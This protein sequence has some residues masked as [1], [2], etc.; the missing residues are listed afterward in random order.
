MRI[1]PLLA[2]TALALAVPVLGNDSEAAV[3]LGGIELVEN[4]DISMDSE[5]LFISKEQVRVRYRYTNHS[6]RDQT[7]VIAFPLPP[8]KADDEAIYGDRMIPDFSTLKFETTV[9]GK[10]VQLQ[11]VKRAEIAGRDITARL[12]ELGWPLE[13]IT[14]SGEP[15]AFL[16]GISAPQAAR[17]AAE[18]LLRKDDRGH[19]WPAWDVASHVTRKQLFPAHRTVEV[20]H[21]YAPMI[22]GSV[23]GTLLPSIRSEYPEH[24]K[25]YCIDK[26]FLRGFDARLAARLKNEPDQMGYSETWIGYILSSGRN[27]RGPIGSF[28]LVV[29]KGRPEN[30]VSFC[31]NGVRKI[32]PTQ[33]EV[34]RTNFEPKGDLD[35][36]I[37]EW[38]SNAM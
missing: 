20:T 15:P 9:D 10:P 26:A 34:R 2:M 31:M 3:S 7:L 13:W 18:G 30:L 14:G 24:L 37:V 27:W 8:V 12:Q 5:D 17:L 23:A 21:R 38:P 33:F 11:L 22:G 28:R 36:L 25:R 6:D 32:S 29:D 4:R 35:I 16:K 19:L 1:T